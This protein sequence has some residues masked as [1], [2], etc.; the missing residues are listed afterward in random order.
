MCMENTHNHENYKD[1]E[2]TLVI[3]GILDKKEKVGNGVL[4]LR[5]ENGRFTSS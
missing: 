3:Y 4:N 5:S 2:A 1:T